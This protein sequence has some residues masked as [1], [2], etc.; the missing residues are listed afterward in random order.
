MI[1][2]KH[3][4]FSAS[5]ETSFQRFQDFTLVCNISL[6]NKLN[7]ITTIK[8]KCVLLCFLLSVDILQIEIAA[9]DSNV[10]QFR[11][12]RNQQLFLCHQLVSNH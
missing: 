8:L 3:F 5:S 11:I 9:L 7:T 4:L 2:L 12:Q 1:I 6:S 10:V